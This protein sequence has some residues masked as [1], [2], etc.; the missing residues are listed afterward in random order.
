MEKRNMGYRDLGGGD[1]GG[2]R[3]SEAKTEV[4]VFEN[5]IW[6]FEST[7]AIECV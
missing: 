5:Y 4:H 1:L 3:C 2:G 7:V 6:P